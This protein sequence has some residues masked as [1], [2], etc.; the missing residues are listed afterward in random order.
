MLGLIA[1]RRLIAQLIRRELRAR[2]VGSLLG[3]VWPL[4]THLLMLA[5]YTFVFGVVLQSRWPPPTAVG[6][7]VVEPHA[8]VDFAI[9]LF[10]GLIVFGIFSEVMSRAPSLVVGNAIYVRSAAFPLEALAPVAV[11]SALANAAL[12]LVV[13]L[14]LIFLRHGSLPLTAL[15]LP[16]VLLPLLALTM[17]LAWF[18]ASLGVFFRDLHHVMPPMMNA[19]LFLSPVFFPASALPDWIERWLILNPVALP[20]EQTRNL[21]VWR[22]PPDLELLALHAVPAAVVAWL[23]FKWFQATSKGFADVL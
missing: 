17:G 3:P 2:Y 20:I 15:W 18:C 9:L 22:Q 10:A 23:G 16:V 4:L 14:G 13:L 11:G 19:M 21:L 12:A 1:H 6:N 8:T 7:A 5:I